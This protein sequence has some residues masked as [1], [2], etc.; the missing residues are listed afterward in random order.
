MTLSFPW[1][2][3]RYGVHLASVAFHFILS[4]ALRGRA[5]VIPTLQKRKQRPREVKSLAQGHTAR[6]Q[7]SWDA[8]LGTSQD[9][10]AEEE[11]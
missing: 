8:V 5:G 7:C 11:A 3:A 2:A 1:L 4:L 6:G 9:A 10:V